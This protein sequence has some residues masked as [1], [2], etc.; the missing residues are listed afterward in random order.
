MDAGTARAECGKSRSGLG[1]TSFNPNAIARLLLAG[2][3]LAAAGVALPACAQVSASIGLESD[4]RFRGRTLSD[5]HPVA[6]ADIGYDDRSGVYLGGA[7]TAVVT[8]SDIGI[9][10]VQGNI[11]F[12]KR[13]SSSLTLDVGVARSQYTSRL[14]SRAVHY[15]EFYAGLS[16]HG[17]STRLYYSPD[18]L[19]PGVGTLYGELDYAMSPA[20]KWQLSAHAGKLVFV[21]N[22]PAFAPRLGSYDWRVGVSRQLGRFSANGALV[23]GGPGQEYYGGELHK[24]VALV[25]GVRFAF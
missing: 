8:G 20:D 13:L 21:A 7:V 24:R 17:F 22:R 11:G 14:R 19:T 16:R 1:P 18:Y 3:A 15:T 10:N 2:C 12:A 4:Y 6:T 9:L 5:S 23:G 25:A